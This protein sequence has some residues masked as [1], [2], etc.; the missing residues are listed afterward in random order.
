MA[1]RQPDFVVYSVRPR[2]GARDVWTRIGAAFKHD[3]ADGLTLLLDALPIGRKVV[4]MPPKADEDDPASEPAEA[5][6][7]RK[8]PT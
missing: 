7:S 1:D 6:K 2:E 4:L 3:R 8:A 5:R